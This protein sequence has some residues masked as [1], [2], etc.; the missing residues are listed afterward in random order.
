[1][2]YAKEKTE[3][4]RLKFEAKGAANLISRWWRMINI[5]KQFLRYRKLNK[6]RRVLKI[7]CSYRCYVSRVELTR[8]K[9]EHA[10]WLE[11]RDSAASLVQALYRRNKDKERVAAMRAI[12]AAADGERKKRI[13]SAREDRVK[14]F[15]FVGEVNLTKVHRRLFDFRKAVDPFKKS[16]ETN[17]VLKL[18]AYYRGNKARRRLKTQRMNHHLFLRRKKKT[19]REAATLKL[20]TRWRSKVLR[21]KFLTENETNVLC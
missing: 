17:A 2:Q 16:R 8:R 11:S 20:Q 18:Q 12:I 9:E 10:S 19:T 3:K 13:E 15:R 5:R 14:T 21:R 1:V 7:Q 4:V 6:G